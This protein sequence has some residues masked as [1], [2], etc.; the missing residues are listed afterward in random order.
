MPGHAANLGP[1]SGSGGLTKFINHGGL[2]ETFVSETSL[3]DNV[4]LMQQGNMN[5]GR[6]SLDRLCGF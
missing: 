4:S 1:R 6:H 3:Q 5:K 2:S